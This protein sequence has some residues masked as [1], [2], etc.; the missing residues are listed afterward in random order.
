MLQRRGCDLAD[1]ASLVTVDHEL[2]VLDFG[3]SILLLVSL[4]DTFDVLEVSVEW[5][6]HE[7]ALFLGLL[8]VILGDGAVV[9]AERFTGAGAILGQLLGNWGLRSLLAVRAPVL[10]VLVAGPVVDERVGHRLVRSVVSLNHGL[11]GGLVLLLVDGPG[12]LEVASLVSSGTNK[13]LRL[14]V[15]VKVLIDDLVNVLDGNRKMMRHATLYPCDLVRVLMFLHVAEGEVPLSALVVLNE[16]QII[17]LVSVV[18]LV[19][20]LVAGSGL[21]NREG[22][23]RGCSAFVKLLSDRR[24]RVLFAV[25][26]PVPGVAVTSPVIDERLAH[27]LVRSL[28]SFHHGLVGSLFLLLLDGPLRLEV[29]ILLGRLTVQILGLHIRIEVIVHNLVDVFERCRFFVRHSIFLPHN[30]VRVLVLLHI[31]EVELPVA[32]DQKL[33]RVILITVVR[34]IRLLGIIDLYERA[35]LTEAPV[36]GRILGAGPVLKGAVRWHESA[37]LG[38]GLL[39]LLELILGT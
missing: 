2:G 14:H 20:F 32:S 39:I 17:L 5:L 26:S 12:R 3:G 15:R 27:R 37:L 19:V 16:G 1:A 38:L 21:G 33:L 4:H 11:V 24:L 25:L 22:S 6:E 34:R 10:S 31:A 28:V 8:I 18:R 29:T 30:R 35:G 7:E 23:T 13:I 36:R 9:L